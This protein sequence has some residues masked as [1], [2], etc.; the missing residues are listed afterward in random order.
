[1]TRLPLVRSF[2]LAGGLL[3][4][5]F[6]HADG[7]ADLK[8]AL[9]RLQAQTPLKATLDVKTTERQGEGADAIDKQGEASVALEDGARGLQVFYA[10]DL[11]A[12]MDAETRQ[13][14]RDPKAKTPTVLALG[15]L[16]TAEVLRMTSAANALARRLD[17]SVFKSEKADT[18]SGRPARLLTFT[19]PLSKLPD[20]QRKYVKEF[21]STLSV[22]IA[23]DGTPLASATTTNLRGRAFVVV[24]FEAL[25]ESS[26]TYGVLGD[27]LMTLRSETHSSSS[28]A[29]EHG[30]QR[31]VK[32]LQ[33]QG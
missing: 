12:R 28:G 13:V 29:G 21:D 5:P 7:L 33:P 24:S 8:A 15:K 10:K 3:A 20:E 26:L 1:M 14:A 6:V 17:E 23:A 25:D 30:E 16:D 11:L 27:R 22:W 32:T 9:A 18:W 4:A 19:M 2:M 31:V